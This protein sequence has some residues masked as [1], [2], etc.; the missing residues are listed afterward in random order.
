MIVLSVKEVQTNSKCK[1]IKCPHCKRG[2]LGDVPK[3][4]QIV[5]TAKSTN[6]EFIIKCPICA[7]YI[8]ITIK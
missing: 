7:A 6:E 8:G 3:N 5:T 4:G 2:R 1:I